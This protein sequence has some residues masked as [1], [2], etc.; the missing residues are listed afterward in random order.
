MSIWMVTTQYNPSR[1]IDVH[2]NTNLCSNKSVQVTVKKATKILGLLYL[3]LNKR[4]PISVKQKL[5]IYQMYVRSMI[6][7]SIQ[8]NRPIISRTNWPKL[9]M[10]KNISLHIIMNTFA[11]IRNFTILD[12]TR[13]PYMTTSLKMY[14]YGFSKH[15]CLKK[16]R[17]DEIGRSTITSLIDKRPRPIDWTTNK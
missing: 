17:I 15:L 8:V 9:K 16:K 3:I 14:S 12:S 1:Y 2:L 10:V 13:L 4:S 5:G 6:N 7:Y 11:Y